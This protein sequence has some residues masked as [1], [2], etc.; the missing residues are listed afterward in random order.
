MTPQ[1][2]SADEAR[3]FWAHKTQLEPGATPDMLR[4][5][6]VDYWA[7]EAI[8]GAFR[9]GPYPGVL[10]ADYGA[11]PEGWGRLTEPA[12]AILH[13]VWAHYQPQLI[14]GWTEE[15]KR[16]A[17]AFSKRIGFERTG[18][19]TLASGARIITQQWRP[20]WA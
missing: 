16:A 11:K 1:K 3:Q 14:V 20:K 19:M 10:M 8:C 6:G 18:E 7:C 17:L 13:A 5:E 15:H 2:I 4:D 12:R 9:Q